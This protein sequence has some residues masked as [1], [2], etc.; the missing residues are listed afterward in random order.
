[1]KKEKKRVNKKFLVL[2]LVLVSLIA[3]SVVMIY[4]AADSSAPA[5]DTLFGR[6]FNQTITQFD[7]KMTLLF[8]VGIALFVLLDAMGLGIAKS[9]LISIPAA[10]ILTVYVTP[11]AVLGILRSYNTLP[12][13]FA[14]LL[15]LLFLFG[16]TYL[17]VTKGER[18]LMGIQLVF[19]IA[20]F[21]FNLIKILASFWIYMDWQWWAWMRVV[22]EGIVNV[23][24][25]TD[26]VT[27]AWYW[28]ALIFATFIAGLMTF[29]NGY[30]L[31]KAMKITA[32][33]EDAA[34]KQKIDAAADMIKDLNRMHKDVASGR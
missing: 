8:M 19:W 31:N 21:T 14:T 2:S 15:P 1:M 24:P 25:A 17:S 6:W 29:Q 10:F 18:T 4:A 3:I 13:A 30:W 9:L 32:G 34:A 22:A 5:G 20:F 11:E 33:V 12:L 23:P 16:L 7:A 26:Q 28:V 27:Y